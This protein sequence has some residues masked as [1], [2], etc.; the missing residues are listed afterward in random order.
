MIFPETESLFAEERLQEPISAIKSYTFRLPLR[1][2]G[3]LGYFKQN[4]I[5]AEKPQIPAKPPFSAKK[6]RVLA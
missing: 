4:G 3:V 5:A 1:S 6:K 2:S